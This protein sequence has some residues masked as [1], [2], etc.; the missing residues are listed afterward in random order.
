[1]RFF[2]APFFLAFSLSLPLLAHACAAER[3]VAEDDP[4]TGLGRP[5]RDGST[6]DSATADA[7]TRDAASADART[8]DATATDAST[9]ARA[10]DA[11]TD[12]AVVGVTISEIFAADILSR[13][14]VEIAG[15]VSTP[16][17]ELKLRIADGTGN[18]LKTVDVANTTAD[19][20]PARGT[21]VVGG[22]AGT[23]VDH[24]VL[25]SAWDLPTDNGT[26]QLV[27]V[28]SSGTTV[29]DV[30]GYGAS[31]AQLTSTPT[32]SREGASAITP[33]AKSLLRKPPQV[34]TGDNA[35]DFCRGNASPNAL[36]VCDL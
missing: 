2:R 12:A 29:V 8:E 31:A 24:G 32:T 20:M 22:L 4:D 27:R 13:R 30:V 28:S 34:D 11:Q 6:P 19:A 7:S 15:P 33:N 14:Y 36:N 25:V 21:W 18:V 16:L 17:G 10:P 5:L 3:V 23:S 1:M 26:V 9:D 35:S